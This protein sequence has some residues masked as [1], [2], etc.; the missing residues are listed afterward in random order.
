VIKGK[1]ILAREQAKTRLDWGSFAA[2][3]HF[4]Q[5]NFKASG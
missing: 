1:V 2:A 3:L 4:N 5:H